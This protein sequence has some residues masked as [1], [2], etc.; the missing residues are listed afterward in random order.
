MILHFDKMQFKYY[1]LAYLKQEAPLRGGANSTEGH[2][3]AYV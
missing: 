3:K 2:T 1:F